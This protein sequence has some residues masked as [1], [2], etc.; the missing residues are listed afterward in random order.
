MCLETTHGSNYQISDP[1]TAAIS[2]A[3]ETPMNI[4]NLPVEIPQVPPDRGKIT[5]HPEQSCD[6]PE[7]PIVEKPSKEAVQTDN[8][9][10]YKSTNRTSLSVKL[11]SKV[12][13]DSFIERFILIN[14]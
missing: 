4:P 12:K 8:P 14:S 13:Y 5:L 3:D 2:S 11:C 10:I 9:I 1:D 7:R 6:S